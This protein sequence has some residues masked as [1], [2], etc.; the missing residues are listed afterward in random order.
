MSRSLSRNLYLIGLVIIIIGVVLIG[1]G[2]AQGTTT[3]TLNSG[4]TVTTPNNAGLFLAGLALTIIGSIP[5][6]VAWIGA[7]V[8]TAQLGQWIW[9]ILLIV[10]S[11]VTML[12]YIFAGPTTPAN[13]NNYP[14]QTP[15]Y[16]QQ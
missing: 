5:I 6:A 9:F 10:F 15:N 1:V 2:A 4:G 16:P 3:T 8:K 12:V 7:L 14:A 13:S 11:G